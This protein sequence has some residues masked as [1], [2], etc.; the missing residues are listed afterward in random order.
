MVP[1]EAIAHTV[2]GRGIE[3][4]IETMWVRQVSGKRSKVGFKTYEQGRRAFEGEAKDFVWCDE[5][6]PVDNYTEILYRLLTTEG[7]AWTTF[8]PLL[9]MNE[10]VMSF[11]EPEN[12]ESRLSK[13]VVQAGWKDGPRLDEEEMRQLVANTPP[14]QVKARTEGEPALG[15][16]AVY[17]IDETEIVVPDI[18]IPEHWPRAYGMD[19]GWNRTR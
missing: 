2:A 9:G 4:S 14:Y 6:P 18:A 1:A 17:L 16:G 8:T 5:E 10:V 11:L 12:D 15:V 7:L 13:Y 19:V 3:G